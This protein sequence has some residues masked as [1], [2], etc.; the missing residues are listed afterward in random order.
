MTRQILHILTF[1]LLLAIILTT[2]C[3]ASG[4]LTPVPGDHAADMQK[5]LDS[6]IPVLDSQ[7]TEICA[8]TSAAAV[9]LKGTENDPFAQ[10]QIFLQLRRDIPACS[11]I[12]LADAHNIVAAVTGNPKNQ[13]YIGHPACT[14]VT[15]EEFAAAGG[16]IISPPLPYQRGSRDSFQRSGV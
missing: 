11:E 4:Q 15:E 3:I 13:E 12:C 7:I 1:C 5:A 6:W 9:E 10:K 2:G 16:C 8:L 14:A